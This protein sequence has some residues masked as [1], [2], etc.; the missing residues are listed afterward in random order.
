MDYIL[1]INQLIH[2]IIE[3]NSYEQNV[4]IVLSKLVT[5]A[6]NRQK[7]RKT[8]E[9]ETNVTSNFQQNVK[10]TKNAKHL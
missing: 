4:Y 2:L 9:R 8:Y 3:S 6:I 1:E 10:I 5:P 7:N